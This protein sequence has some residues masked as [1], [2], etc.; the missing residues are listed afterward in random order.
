MDHPYRLSENESIIID[1]RISD[2]ETQMKG[3]RAWKTFALILSGFMILSGFIAY[4][5]HRVSESKSTCHDEV[6]VT[7]PEYWRINGSAVTS[8]GVACT[9]PR[10]RGA[11]VSSAGDAI[12]FACTCH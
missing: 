12:T 10:Q 1:T 2:L 3:A 4:G 5:S 11:I 8:V 9:H 7:S 6:K